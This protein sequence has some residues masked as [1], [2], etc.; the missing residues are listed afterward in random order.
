MLL[1]GI[2]AQDLVDLRAPF[3]LNLEII[4]EQVSAVAATKTCRI[5]IV[6]D[7]EAILFE[8]LL[9]YV[10]YGA[11]ERV[12]ATLNETMVGRKPKRPALTSEPHLVRLEQTDLVTFYF[13]LLFA[14]PSYL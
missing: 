10:L 1:G 12:F 8:N 7:L 5:V 2:Y 3:G 13:V 6:K 9:A 11:D 4:S 14:Y